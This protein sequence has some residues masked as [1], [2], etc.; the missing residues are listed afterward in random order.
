ME[1]IIPTIISSELDQ[2]IQDKSKDL[3]LQ[4]SPSLINEIINQGIKSSMNQFEILEKLNTVASESK[5]ITEDFNKISKKLINARFTESVV[6]KV[7]KEKKVTNKNVIF[8]STLEHIQ[9]VMSSKNIDLS[10]LFDNIYDVSESVI[11]FINKYTIEDSE[12]T[13]LISQVL[14]NAVEDL[15][16]N[17]KSISDE[18][19]QLVKQVKE[20]IQNT[21]PFYIK[22]F[23]EADLND[24]D[25]VEIKKSVMRLIFGCILN[26]LRRN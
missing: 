16:S 19:L 22:G 21:L 14:L 12:K 11:G 3:S 1:D 20:F 9:W 13:K 26:S 17:S 24:E 2:L 5:D 4:S 7:K 6:K 25:I 15:I 8:R 23:V 10:N 18:N